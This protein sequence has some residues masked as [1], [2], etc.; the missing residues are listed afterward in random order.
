MWIPGYMGFNGET[1][2][3]STREYRGRIVLVVDTA[4]RKKD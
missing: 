1:M 3:I 4:F 2:T